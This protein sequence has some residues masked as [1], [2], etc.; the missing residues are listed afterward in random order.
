MYYYYYYKT[1]VLEIGNGSMTNAEY[2]THFS[3]W[4]I[5]KAPLIMGSDLS[6][7]TAE[8]LA[9][10][11]NPEVIAVIKIHWV[12]KENELAFHQDNRQMISVRLLLLVVHHCQA[13]IPNDVNGR[14]M[15]KMVVF[16]RYSMVNV[17][18]LINV[19]QVMK[20]ISY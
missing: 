17:F 12:F 5:S 3:L 10:L 2:I 13:S 4:S 20:L 8:T 11:T 19:I 16:D 7:M 1:V 14:I 15:L 18:L 9:I 6:Q